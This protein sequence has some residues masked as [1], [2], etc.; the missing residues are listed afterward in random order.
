MQPPEDEDVGAPWSGAPDDARGS[1]ETR[2]DPPGSGGT[3]SA[4]SESD[5]H[6]DPAGRGWRPPGGD[7]PRA[8]GSA[9]S[10]GPA[11]QASRRNREI[12]EGVARSVERGREPNRV[13]GQDVLTLSFR[14]HEFDADGNLVRET[15][16]ELRGR[17]ITGGIREGDHV[18]LEGAW[19]A[20]VVNTK[21]VTI[22]RDG[23]VVGVVRAMRPV[24]P[25]QIVLAALMVVAFVLFVVFLVLRARETTGPRGNTGPAAAV[26]T[27]PSPAKPQPSATEMP[28]A[29]ET[30]SGTPTREPAQ[31]DC[32]PS[33]EPGDDV[34][35]VPGQEV[36]WANGS[37][38]SMD[39]GLNNAPSGFTPQRLAPGEQ[40]SFVFAEPGT[41]EY[42]CAFPS[43]AVKQVGNV[44]VEAA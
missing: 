39:L 38:E 44:T 7:S 16:V 11:R 26:A 41:Y 22:H 4:G 5:E 28:S 20:G 13:A 12:V 27:S 40:F 36:R 6:E 34:S 24:A 33:D 8:G 30:P 1:S 10:T 9:R 23:Q 2:P 21:A 32:A 29:T 25:W 19:S 15:P 37:S 3:S 35:I 43:S 31:I 42:V 17:A 14:V 18:S